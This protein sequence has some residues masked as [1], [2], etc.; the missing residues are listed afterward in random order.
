MSK[1]PTTQFLTG[2][3]VKPSSISPIGTVTFT[4]GTNDLTPNQIQCEAYGYKYNK[5]TRTCSAF[6]Y[7]TNLDRNISN[8]NNKINGAGNTTLPNT[9][10]TYIIGQKNTVRGDSTNNIVVGTQNE[11][12]NG[13]SNANVYGTLGEATADNSIVLGGNVAA[14]LLGERQSIQVIYGVQTTNGTNT[15]SYLNNTTDQLLAVPE[16]A[17]MYFHADV[18]AV[19][20]GGTGTGNLG[21]YASFVERG[22]II[23]ES[24]TL[25]VNRE[26]DAI[27]SNGTVSNWQPTGIASGTNFAMR[28]RGAT[29][30]TIEWCS[31][32]RITQIKTG[33]AL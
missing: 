23:N 29:D 2:F 12:A 32:I 1:I 22:V 27:K 19:R 16:N 11:I 3:N 21:D 9:N 15:V 17:A 14:D 30:V 26:R 4:D 18:I 33:V 31:N 7:S 24:G 20:V 8:T 28:V 25:S 13:V 5:V 10:N 6:K